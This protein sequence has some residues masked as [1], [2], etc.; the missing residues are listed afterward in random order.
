MG[1]RKGFDCDRVNKE[2]EISAIV[3]RVEMENENE[4]GKNL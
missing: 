1:K 3:I 4:E 2:L